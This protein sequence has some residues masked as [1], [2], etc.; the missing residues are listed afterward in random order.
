M[1]LVTFCPVFLL[2]L[3]LV[4]VIGLVLILFLVLFLVLL[5]VLVIVTERLTELRVLVLVLAVV[6]IFCLDYVQVW[7]FPDFILIVFQVLVIFLF[8]LVLEPVQFWSC[9]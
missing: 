7:L 5:L 2:G 9:V 6:L 8:I 4:L 1:C 3:M